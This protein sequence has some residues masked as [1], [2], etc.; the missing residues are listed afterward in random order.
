MK[1]FAPEGWVI[2]GAAIGTH[3][4]K[5]VKQ[6][7]ASLWFQLGGRF[8]FGRAGISPLSAA[9]SNPASDASRRES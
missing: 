1:W 7:D 8:R 5:L 9:S 2:H 3:G 6:P 4:K